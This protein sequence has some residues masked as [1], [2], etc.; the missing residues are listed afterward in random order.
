MSRR[1]NYLPHANS[2][3]TLRNLPASG[4]LTVVQTMA[5]MFQVPSLLRT[6]ADR[7]FTAIHMTFTI[8]ITQII[9][10]TCQKNEGGIL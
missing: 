1:V 2:T 3:L 5:V 10:K 9:E 6:R 7:Y 8:V 4:Y